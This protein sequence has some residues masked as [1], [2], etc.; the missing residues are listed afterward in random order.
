MRRMG[1]IYKTLVRG[2]NGHPLNE[3][4]TA[5]RNEVAVRTM[6]LRATNPTEVR[7]TSLMT[8][9]PTEVQLM[10]LVTTNPAEIHPLSATSRRKSV[11]TR[12]G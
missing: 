11:R 10:S 6:S 1:S 3:V 12:I 4:E 9:N 7:L 5:I 8:T 2:R